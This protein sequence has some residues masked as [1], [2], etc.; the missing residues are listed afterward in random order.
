ME[1]Q[2]QL[3]EEEV[4]NP[5]QFQVGRNPEPEEQAQ[6]QDDENTSDEAGYTDGEIEYA[7]GAGTD[8][9]EGMEEQNGQQELDF[10]DDTEPDEDK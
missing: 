7:D 5:E 10:E 1:N 6:N 9:E 2:D 8:L 4:V 3:H